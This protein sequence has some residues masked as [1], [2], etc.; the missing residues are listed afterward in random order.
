ML[1]GID[2][3]NTVLNYEDSIRQA[4]KDVLGIT[5]E[6]NVSKT[7]AKGAIVE[8]FGHVAWTE[9]QGRIYGDYSTHTKLFSGVLEFIS[10]AQAQGIRVMVIS[11]KTR[12]AVS[13]G[14][15]DLRAFAL[16][17]LARLGLTAGPVSNTTTPDWVVFCETKED[18]VSKI[19]EAEV[20]VFIDDLFEIVNVLPVSIQRFHIFCA[21]RHSP[22]SDVT[23]V[24]NWWE[25]GIFFS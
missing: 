9:L 18:K 7:E 13:G 10:F 16:E 22:A 21:D 24:K 15:S 1:I 8:K 19:R 14:E 4:A 17:N 3:D 2:L 23:C 5:L 6:G 12:Y 25:L 11:H 20:D